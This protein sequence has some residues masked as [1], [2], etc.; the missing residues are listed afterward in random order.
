MDKANSPLQYPDE[1]EMDG[2]QIEVPLQSR[3]YV[4][5]T[6]IS[7]SEHVL[8][9]PLFDCAVYTVNNSMIVL[10]KKKIT[11][12][13]KNLDASHLLCLKMTI[14]SATED[15]NSPRTEAD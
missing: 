6:K 3:Y 10:K 11:F 1:M 7:K 5:R 15:F 4:Y 2:N 12:L 13:K 14:K 9:E 8:G